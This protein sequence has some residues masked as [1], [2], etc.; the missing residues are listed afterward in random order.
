MKYP[1]LDELTVIIPTYERNACVLTQVRGLLKLTGIEKVRIIVLDNCS[2]IPVVDTLKK[3]GISSNN[4]TVIRHNQNIGINGNILECFRVCV[5]KWLWILG[6]D[7]EVDKYALR[8]INNKLQS[9]DDDVA[10]LNFDSKVSSDL[11]KNIK[12]VMSLDELPEC[13][14]G[15]SSIL[16]ISTNIYNTKILKKYIGDGILFS[17]SFQPHCAMLISCLIDK[18]GAL[19]TVPEK[20]VNWSDDSVLSWSAVHMSFARQTIFDLRGL[21]DHSSYPILYNYIMKGYD[22]WKAL[23]KLNDFFCSEDKGLASKKYALQQTFRNVKKTP[24]SILIFAFYTVILKTNFTTIFFGKL[25]R[26]PIS[27]Y[28]KKA[29]K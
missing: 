13:N 20:I 5:T 19:I 22:D 10:C 16:F 25:C 26:L 21:R 24:M 23:L 17:Y 7:D 14:A 2:S 1:Y 12:R 28:Q 15:Y 3:S 11:R 18:R 4:L 9:I 27:F 8:T 29:N 6:D